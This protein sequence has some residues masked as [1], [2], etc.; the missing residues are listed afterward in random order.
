MPTGG[1]SPSLSQRSLAPKMSP[2]RRKTPLRLG[3]QAVLGLNLAFG[4]DTG[5]TRFDFR[6]C[7]HNIL[8][9]WAGGREPVL[10]R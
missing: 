2:V 5:P 6:V 1:G 10:N 7:A 3:L 4:T 9:N 8:E